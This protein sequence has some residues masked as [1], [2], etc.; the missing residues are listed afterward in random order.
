VIWETLGAKI[1]END[2]LSSRF[3]SGGS[4]PVS[5]G[6]GAGGW[7]EQDFDIKQVI[8]RFWVSTSLKIYRLPPLQPTHPILD[9]SMAPRVLSCK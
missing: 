9:E 1:V 7:P 4:G 2:I 6:S 5:G 8:G 3:T